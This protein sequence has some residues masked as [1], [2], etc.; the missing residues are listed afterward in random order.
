MPDGRA[1]EEYLEELCW[2]GLR[3]R[4]E[5]ASSKD[6]ERLRYELEVIKHTQFADY[7]LVVWDI[8]KF[9]RERDIFFAVRGSAAASLVL[10]FLCV[11]NIN[12][13]PYTLVFERFLNLERKEM[14]DIDMDFQD[15]RR[16]EVLNYVMDKYGREHVAQIITFGTL[17]AKASVRDV[18]RALGMPYADVDRVARL[19]PI[20]LG[21]TLDTAPGPTPELKGLDGPDEG[22]KKLGDTA[23]ALEG[24]HLHSSTHAAGVVTSQGPLDD[25]VPLQKPI[26]G[27]DDGVA[28]TQYAMAPCADLGLLKMDFLGLSNLTIRARARNLIAETQGK[29]LEL[30]EI[31]LDD[32]KTFDLLS[33]G[34]TCAVFP[35]EGSGMPR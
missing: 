16:E 13:M 19:I 22:I 9:V 29:Q 32:V 11:T 35:R 3:R 8:A 4:V 21:M 28:M 15:D 31:P 12:P 25:V 2:E 5:N 14:P 33:R 30:T 18:G 23:R 6:E 10:Y 17:G 34:E 24:L 20:R 1:A 27:N 26:R 7:F